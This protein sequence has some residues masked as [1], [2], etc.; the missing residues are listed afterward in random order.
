[1]ICGLRL[2]LPI[3]GLICLHS[4]FASPASAQT[5][6]QPITARGVEAGGGKY[7]AKKQEFNE[8]TVVIVSGQTSGT[9]LKLA[10][11]LQNVLDRRDT[12]ELRILPVVGTPGPQNILDVLFLRGV[13]MCMTETDYFDYFKGLDADLY[14]D[15]GSKINYIAKLYNTEFHILARRD[16]TSLEQLRGKKVNFYTRL[17]SADISGRSLFKLLGVDVEVLN[18][19]QPVA[20]AKL[21]SGE[22]D[23]VLRLAGAP[24]EAFAGIKPEDGLHFVPIDPSSLSEAERK[25]FGAVFKS[26]LPAKLRAEDYPALI[27]AGQTVAT[28]ASSV[29]LAVYAWPEGSD[30]YRRV[31]KFVEAFFENFDKLKEKTRHPKWQSTNLAA[32]VPGWTRFKAAQQ[33][34]DGKRTELAATM[35]KRD[36]LANAFRAFLDS[37]K[38]KHP[39]VALSAPQANA[40][41]QQFIKWR[42]GQTGEAAAQ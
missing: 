20:T 17:S 19:D 40:L 9:Y 7:Q 24:V 25:R 26:Y 15:I 3:L 18:L 13:D 1:M 23:A 36:P 33:W 6:V 32:D 2:P 10:E 14:G 21:K 29:V 28:V 42:S 22:I 4:L 12:N 5:A 31:A 35:D 38:K 30:R 37:Y 34:L 16:V 39:G 27:P 8:N 11:D 41:W